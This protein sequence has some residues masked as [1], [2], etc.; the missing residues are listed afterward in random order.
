MANLTDDRS[1]STSIISVPTLMQT[2]MGVVKKRKAGRKKFTE[3]RHP[4]YK[5]VRQRCGKW[6]CELRQPDHKKSRIWL[7]TFTSPDMAARAY[8]VA[9]LA[10]KGESASLNFPNEATALPHFESNA[11]TVK[12]IQCAAL[13]AA[14][15]FLEVKGKASSSSSLKLEKVEEE[16]VRKVVYLDEEELFNMPGLIDSMA[17]G[18]IL[19][20]PSLQKGFN[21][22][23]YDDDD[24]GNNTTDISLWSD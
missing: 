1:S 8:D 14:E 12:D 16:E 23:E 9:A 22:N 24:W 15:A 10:L 11:Y 19:T 2:S 6:V 3:T 17:E 13:E 21:W 7:G 20:P 4:V 18:L 5:G